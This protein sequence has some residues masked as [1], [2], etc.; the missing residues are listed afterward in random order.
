MPEYNRVNKQAFMSLLNFY[1]PLP[2]EIAIAIFC[3]VSHKEEDGKYKGTPNRWEGKVILADKIQY[4]NF[5]PG[6]DGWKLKAETPRIAKMSLEM[7][8]DTMI[9][10]P[11]EPEEPKPRGKKSK[12]D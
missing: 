7:E 3:K 12:E 10:L 5:F 9:S 4:F 1:D 6:T 8:A 11:P 2:D